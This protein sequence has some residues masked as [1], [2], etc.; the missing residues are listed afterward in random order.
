[1]PA[2]PAHCDGSKQRRRKTGPGCYSVYSLNDGGKTEGRGT[3][4]LGGQESTAW[5]HKPFVYKREACPKPEVAGSSPVSRSI[6]AGLRGSVAASGVGVAEVRPSEAA[7]SLRRDL[8][9]LVLRAIVRVGPG[10]RGGNSRRQG[11][12]GLQRALCLRARYQ[13]LPHC[14]TWAFSFRFQADHPVSAITR[15]LE[16]DIRAL[17]SSRGGRGGTRARLWPPVPMSW[18]R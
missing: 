4:E 18:C 7:R 1:M 16:A 5:R 2:P 8:T 13:S 15:K 11:M 3:S 10:E 12:K 17:R 9:R 6:L 14:D